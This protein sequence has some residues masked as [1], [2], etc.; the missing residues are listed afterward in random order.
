MEDLI[1]KL[2]GYRESAASM[3]AKR[4]LLREQV[5]DLTVTVEEIKANVENLVKA[6]WVLAEVSKITQQKFKEYIESLVTMAIR[7]VFDR[8][9]K[10]LVDFELKRNKSECN[11]RVQEGENP[12]YIPKD[13]MG[14]GMVDIIA[15]A[16]RVV[17]WSLQRPKSR[18]VFI[19]D[20]PM[21]F[22]GKGEL[23]QRAGQ[24]LRE[25]SDRLSF[26]LI[27]VTHEPEF[28]ELAD[29]S[30]VVEHN[31]TYSV[32]KVPGEK[33]IEEV[34]GTSLLKRRNK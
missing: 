6:R 2:K 21:K 24:M 1:K 10:F 19:L 3:T 18:N 13:E 32:V 8:P 28:M 11:F 33:R 16:L 15:I 7:S 34:Q 30:W 23:L 14:G 17:M 4:E 26:Q 22:V 29:K 12:P 9:F 25:I 20:E 31:G 5:I 27:I